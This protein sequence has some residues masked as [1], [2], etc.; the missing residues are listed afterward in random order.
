MKTSVMISSL[1]LIT[2]AETF[3][4]TDKILS[5]DVICID[6]M[7]NLEKLKLEINKKAIRFYDKLYLPILLKGSPENLIL[8]ATKGVP[9]PYG[10]EG[11]CFYDGNLNSS[12]A[13]KKIYDLSRFYRLKNLEFMAEDKWLYETSIQPYEEKKVAREKILKYELEHPGVIRAIVL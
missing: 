6:E 2:D 9:V 8:K 13:Q 4:N 1:P 12:L 5:V 3:F 11:V 10:F 7:P